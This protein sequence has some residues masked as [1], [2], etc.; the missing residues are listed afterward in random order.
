MSRPGEGIRQQWDHTARV[1]RLLQNVSIGLIIRM[2]FTITERPNRQQSGW[3][4]LREPTQKI[5][6]QQLT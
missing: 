6:T 1:W 3:Q 4:Q 2:Q 5:R